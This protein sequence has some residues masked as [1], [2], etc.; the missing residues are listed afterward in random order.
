EKNPFAPFRDQKIVAKFLRQE[1]VV[2]I[3]LTGG[4]VAAK[5]RIERVKEVGA[6][7]LLL[8]QPAARPTEIRVRSNVQ[9]AARHVLVRQTLMII[10]VAK[11][12][13]IRI[14]REPTT[15]AKST[16]QWSKNFAIG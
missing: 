4:H 8:D 2:V 3:C 13:P 6:P 10:V 9:Q 5:L 7:R 1:R 11:K 16:G 14:K 12:I 15:I